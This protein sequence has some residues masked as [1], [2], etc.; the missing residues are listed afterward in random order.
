MSTVDLSV[1]KPSLNAKSKNVNSLFEY[2]WNM[3]GYD[4][5]IEIPWKAY[6]S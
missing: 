1:L 6:Y 4:S 3:H 5:K 2:I